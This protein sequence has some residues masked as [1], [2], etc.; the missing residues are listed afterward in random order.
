MCHLLLHSMN[1]AET[2]FIANHTVGVG[3][4]FAFDVNKNWIMWPHNNRPTPTLINQQRR[5]RMI[6][7]IFRILYEVGTGKGQIYD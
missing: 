7:K 4:S 6:K 5:H 1:L 2:I 3:L